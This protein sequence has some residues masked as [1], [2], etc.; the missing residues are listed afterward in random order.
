VGADLYLKSMCWPLARKFQK[1]QRK[2]IYVSENAGVGEASAAPNAMK[3]FHDELRASGGLT[4][5][6][7]AHLLTGPIVGMLIAE[8]HAVKTPCTPSFEEISIIL[9]R[10][11]TELLAMSAPPRKW[12]RSLRAAP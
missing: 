8:G 12:T 3:E 9:Q 10:K 4:R 2:A 6:I 7:N 11:R 1:L 5:G